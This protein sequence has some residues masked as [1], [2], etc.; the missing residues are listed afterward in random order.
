[1][2]GLNVLIA[3]EKHNSFLPYYSASIS[4]LY[5]LSRI[6]TLLEES[7]NGDNSLS[8]NTCIWDWLKD[9]LKDMVGHIVWGN[10]SFYI[11]YL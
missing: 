1:M 4:F 9:S 11:C 7:A 5:Y 8:I 2:C 10:L 6:D 3:K